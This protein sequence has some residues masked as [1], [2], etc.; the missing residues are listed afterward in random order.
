MNTTTHDRQ[1]TRTPQFGGNSV[2]ES[3]SLITLL[4]QRYLEAGLKHTDAWDAALADYTH[5]FDNAA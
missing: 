3:E 5:G 2:T 4:F 1:T